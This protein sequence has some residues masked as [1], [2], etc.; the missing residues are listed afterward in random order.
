MCE[1]IAVVKIKVLW[2]IGVRESAAV[3]YTHKNLSFLSLH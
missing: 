3:V 1:N 2:V